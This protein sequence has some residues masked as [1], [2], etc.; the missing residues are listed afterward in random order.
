VQVTPNFWTDPAKGIPYYLAVQTPEP[1]VASLNALTN[2]P[3]STAL[4][5]QGDPVPGLLSNVATL[6]R[7]ALPTNANQANIQPVYEV[8][9]NLQGRDLGSVAGEIEK[10][11]S[12]VRRSSRP[13]TRSR[14]W[15]RFKA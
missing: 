13:A 14:Y 10:I 4:S 2:T 9:A 7:T 1:Q 5:P 8:Y 15:A 6:T 3:V 12:V 11:V